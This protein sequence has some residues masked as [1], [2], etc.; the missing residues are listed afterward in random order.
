MMARGRELAPADA[1]AGVAA[2]IAS[3]ATMPGESFWVGV[4]Q[5]RYLP[6]PRGP[7]RA[8]VDSLLFSSQDETVRRMA[9]EVR[10]ELRDE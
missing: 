3:L 5:L 10:R 8:F 2:F 1:A 6:E 7:V 9:A 4:H